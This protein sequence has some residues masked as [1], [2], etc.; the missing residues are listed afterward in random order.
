MPAPCTYA[1]AGCQLVVNVDASGRT[2][3]QLICCVHAHT[4]CLGRQCEAFPKCAKGCLSFASQGY[5]DESLFG[6]ILESSFSYWQP[7]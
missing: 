4:W 6:N 3:V 5:P 7:S 1:V 2:V